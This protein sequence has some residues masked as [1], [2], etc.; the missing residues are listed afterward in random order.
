MENIDWKSL[1]TKELFQ[2]ANDLKKEKKCF[3]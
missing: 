1:S 2:I 3:F